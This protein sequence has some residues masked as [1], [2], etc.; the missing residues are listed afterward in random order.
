MGYTVTVAHGVNNARHGQSKCPI[1]IHQ[2][3]YNQVNNPYPST[4]WISQN[5][6]VVLPANKMNMFLNTVLHLISKEH[7]CT[8]LNL[9]LLSRSSQFS[10]FHSSISTFASLFFLLS[11]VAQP[12]NIPLS[13]LSV[14][15][16][17]SISKTSTLFPTLPYL[18]ALLHLQVK[19]PHSS[20]LYPICWHWSIYK[21]TCHTHPRSTLSVGTG[22]STSKP[23]TLFLTLPYM[24]AL[25]H[26]QVNLPHSSRSTLS[27]GTDPSTS[28]PATLFP[29]LPY[30]LALLHLQVNLPHS[31][32]FYP[33]CWHC[34]IYK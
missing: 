11:L 19:L 3:S 17:P 25:I 24:L 32:P 20:P 5:I 29:T 21:L 23:A 34:S 4:Q 2:H 6:T 1:P 28:K 14:G 7:T 15:T 26:I 27:V 16:D 22:P 8:C 33:I 31:S 30:L 18:L 12:S 13:T 9:F 10:L